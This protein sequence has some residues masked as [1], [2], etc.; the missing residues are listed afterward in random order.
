M[1]NKIYA[2]GR[3]INSFMMMAIYTDDA[4]SYSNP[5]VA[6][7]GDGGVLLGEVEG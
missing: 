7:G 2:G 3:E 6:D 4:I 1:L 5:I